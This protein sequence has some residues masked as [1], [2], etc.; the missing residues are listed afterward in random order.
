MVAGLDS[1]LLEAVSVDKQ[2][3]GGP[4]ELLQGEECSSYKGL[5][6]TAGFLV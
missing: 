2:P 4:F 3:S 6:R 5:A 1:R